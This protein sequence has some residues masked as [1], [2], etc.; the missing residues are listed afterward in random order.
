RT[1]PG[2][3][4]TARSD[5]TWARSVDRADEWARSG[6]AAVLHQLLQD[7][8]EEAGGP[9]EAPPQVLPAAG[10]ERVAPAVAGEPGVLRGRLAGGGAAGRGAEAAEAEHQP[11]GVEAG[12]L[13]RAGDLDALGGGGDGV[14][15]RAAADGAGILGDALVRRRRRQLRGRAP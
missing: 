8:P 12:V 7:Q 6:S 10:A 4:R 11:G 13:V 15:A 1:A 2:Q 5:G 3:P 14:T 9:L